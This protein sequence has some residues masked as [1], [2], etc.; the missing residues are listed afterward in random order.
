VPKDSRKLVVFGTFQTKLDKI[1][2]FWGQ[3]CKLP[4]ELLDLN[5]LGFAFVETVNSDLFESPDLKH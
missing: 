4:H 2:L 1:Q 5:K 3:E